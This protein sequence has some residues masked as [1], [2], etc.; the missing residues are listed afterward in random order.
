VTP[1]IAAETRPSTASEVVAENIAR[2]EAG[3]PLL[4]EV[5]RALGY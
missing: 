2:V 1:H 5:D 4:H 3:A